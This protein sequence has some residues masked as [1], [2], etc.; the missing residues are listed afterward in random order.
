MRNVLS[1]FFYSDPAKCPIIEGQE[2]ISTSYL[3]YCLDES[4]LDGTIPDRIYFPENTEQTAQ[5]LAEIS[6]RGESVT[7]SG[8]RTGI[9]GGA[10]NHA[11]NIL[12]LERNTPLAV[13]LS[14]DRKFTVTAGAGARLSDLNNFLKKRCSF[15]DGNLFFPVDPTETTASLGGMAAANASGAR[16]LYYGPCRDWINGLTVV[17]QDGAVLKLKRGEC[18]CVDGEFILESAGFKKH[19]LEGIKPPATKHVAGYLLNREM[20]LID[21]FIGGE[22]TLGVITELELKLAPAWKK[23]LYLCIFAPERCL[24]APLVHDLKEM[25]L[26]SLEFMDSGS[27]KILKEFKQEIAAASFVPDFP[28]DTAKVFYLEIGLEHESG[29][30]EQISSLESILKVHGMDP[31][32]TWA[33]FSRQYQDAMK[34]FRH[35]LPERINS[36]ISRRKLKNPDLTKVATDMAVPDEALSEIMSCYYQELGKLGLQSAVFGHIGNG[37]L[38]VNILPD[39]KADLQKAKALYLEFAA[40]AV[41]LGGSVAA[42]HGIGRLKKNLLE[43]QYSKAELQEMRSLKEFFDPEY[44]LNPGVLFDK[45]V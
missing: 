15:A 16:T 13:N 37:H 20:D 14:S 38:H 5:A 10:V 3:K 19:R 1:A 8:G 43:V 40:K 24:E 36:L 22:G 17:L 29:I 26:I 6:A 31:S 30:P 23:C 12:S 39:C 18:F 35:A 9:V 34:K 41:S 33:G 7:I 4:R 42:E 25:N 44:R 28:S 32:H 45:P 27:L 11:L 21:L 2:K